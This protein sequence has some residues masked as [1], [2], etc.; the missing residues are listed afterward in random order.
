MMLAWLTSAAAC[1]LA[2]DQARGRARA[3]TRNMKNDQADL[4]E[5]LDEG[6]DVGVEDVV[7]APPARRAEHGRAEDDAGDDLAHDLG[8]AEAAEE[9][10]DEARP[11]R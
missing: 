1:P 4:G 8:L 3:P 5:D 10:A 2:P 6:H 9:G 11:R 7:R